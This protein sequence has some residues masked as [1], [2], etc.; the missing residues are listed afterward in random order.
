VTKLPF[1]QHE[2]LALIAPRAVLVPGNPQYEWLA[3]ESGYVGCMAARSVW[4]ALGISDRFGFS[5]YDDHT[6]CLLP[7]SQ[8]LDVIAFVQEFLLGD[9]TANT[10]I[11][12][13]KW[14]TVLTSWIPWTTYPLTN[15]LTSV[16][17]TGEEP[18]GYELAQNYP[19]PFNPSTMIRFAVHHPSHVELN[20]Y[21]ALGRLVRTLI[22]EEESTE[23]HEVVWDGKSGSGE[24]V[25]SGV[26]VYRI[27][28]GGFVSSQK[29]ICIR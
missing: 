5:R 15:D 13:T 2:V 12:S 10:N 23:R 3:D 18:D 24:P 25:A 28:A 20:I 27:K 29:M 22:D 21:D 4:T 1:D 8:K 19:N 16:T 9:S 14:R 7:N 11:L 6:H 26:Y 17:N